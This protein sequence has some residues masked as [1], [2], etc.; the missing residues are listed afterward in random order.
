MVA[1]T[2]GREVM[3]TVNDTLRRG[4]QIYVVYPLVEESEKAD[5]K[6]ATHGFER[7]RKALPGVPAALVHGR[8]DRDLRAQAMNDFAAG[9][10]R[11]LVATTVV[12][13]GVDVPNATLLI[14]QHAE[15]FGLAQLHQLRGRVG[16]GAQP[17]PRA[18]HRRPD[19]PREASSGWR[20]SS[21]PT[22]ASTSPKP[23]CASAAP[24]SGSAPARPVTSPSSASPTWSATASTS[25]QSAAPPKSSCAATRS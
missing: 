16:R 20:S 8:L 9:R 15:R 10:V 14:V 19:H 1:P 11:V 5:L 4:E 17:G 22:A 12:E 21:A 3:Q 2:A 6:D 7:L 24:A 23:T 18:L 13:V 25:P